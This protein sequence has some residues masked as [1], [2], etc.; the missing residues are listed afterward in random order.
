MTQGKEEEKVAYVGP[1]GHSSESY[2]FWDEYDLKFKDD[3]LKYK[4][5]K[6]KIY[7][8]S[9]EKENVEEKY[10]IGLA[11]TYENFYTGEKQVIEHK[12]SDLISGFKELII[13]PGDYLKQFHINF[14]D[15]FEYIS[16]IGFTTYKNKVISIGVKDG[17]DKR[18]KE[19][20]EE[21]VIVGTYGYLDKTINCIGCLFV[22]KKDYL[23]SYLF[24]V[25][26]MRHMVKNEKYK[27]FKTDWDSK[28]KEL[29]ITYQFVW[30]AINLPDAV[31]SKIIKYCII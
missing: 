5:I 28:Y 12:G 8:Q 31:F 3:I 17:L 19:N 2:T 21:R 4:I 6:V 20:N 13:E 24:W 1:F 10:I 11:F 18:I 14:K 23:R 16:Q 30:R 22:K 25:F 7:Y 9:E 15:N 27:Q 29:D 26:M